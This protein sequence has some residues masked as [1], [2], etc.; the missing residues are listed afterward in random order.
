VAAKDGKDE[1]REKERRQQEGD[2][3]KRD[4]V[5]D[6]EALASTKRRAPTSGALLRLLSGN[7]LEKRAFFSRSE[8]RWEPETLNE[9]NENPFIAFPGPDGKLALHLPQFL[10]HLIHARLGIACCGLNGWCA[11]L[12][13]MPQI[14]GKLP[15]IQP[16]LSL[17]AVRKVMPE[18]VER[19]IGNIGPFFCG[20]R[21][22]PLFEPRMNSRFA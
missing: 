20:G 11:A 14:D 5:D 12:G 22:L 2:E 9:L 21:A 19:N 13:N 17:C 1:D 8:K 3:G 4:R 6:Y 18:I 15:L 7:V 10:F 16:R